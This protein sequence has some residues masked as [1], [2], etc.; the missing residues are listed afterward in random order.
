MADNALTVALMVQIGYGDDK[1]WVVSVPL[2][3][4]ET[5]L[6]DR[7]DCVNYEDAEVLD[8]KVS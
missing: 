8:R 6:G 2:A 7:L 3:R 1:R 4:Q 5:L